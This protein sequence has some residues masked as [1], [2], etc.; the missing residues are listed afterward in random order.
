MPA[1][2]VDV[3]VSGD[4]LARRCDGG[5]LLESFGNLSACFILTRELAL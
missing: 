2:F 1:I 4:F 3:V 5:C